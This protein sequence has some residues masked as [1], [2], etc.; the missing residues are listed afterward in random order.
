MKTARLVCSHFSFTQFLLVSVLVFLGLAGSARPAAGKDKVFVFY[1]RIDAVNRA[2]GTFTLLAEKRRYVFHV[3]ESTRFTKNKRPLT[4][5]DLRNGQAVGVEMKPGP[6]QE[7][8]AT[9]VDLISFG[10][11]ESIIGA[12]KDPVPFAKGV[13]EPLLAAI[14]PGGATLSASQVKPLIVYSTWPSETIYTRGIWH[15]KLGVFLLSVRPDGTV[16][17]V[18]VLQSIGHRG[19]D[20]DV[21]KALAKW[22]FRPNSVKEVRVP[23]YYTRMQ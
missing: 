4:F 15:L 23:S 14:T 19:M 13:V 21:T 18:E 17:K 12:S 6:K 22:R 7:G 8:I 10:S 20:G 9:T 16:S 5:S 1:G 3:N 11:L 2:A